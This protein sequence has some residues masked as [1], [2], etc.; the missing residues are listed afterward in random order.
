MVG[1]VV[2]PLQVFDEINDFIFGITGLYTEK[3]EVL[4]NL[5]PVEC[6]ICG[7]ILDTD[8]LSCS[9]AMHQIACKKMQ[10]FGTYEEFFRIG[11]RALFVFCKGSCLGVGVGGI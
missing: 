3:S 6:S 1:L 5:P 11:G 10:Y 8:F 9:F 2:A 4:R 7:D